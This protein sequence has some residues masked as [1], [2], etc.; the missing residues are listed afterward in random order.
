MEDADRGFHRAVQERGTG[1]GKAQLIPASSA[2]IDSGETADRLALHRDGVRRGHG[3]RQ[4]D[5]PGAA[6]CTRSTRW[7]SLRTFAM[8][9]AYA[10]ERGIIHRDIKPANIMVGQDGAVKVAD[11]GLAKVSAQ[12][13]HG[14]EPDP[15]RQCVMGT[16]HYMA[17]EALS[18]RERR[19]P[20]GGHLRRRRD[21]LPDAHREAPAGPV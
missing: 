3:C 19:G 2:S 8:L 9:S 14:C 13:S 20:E 15:Q 1:D 6:A 7:R 21:A 16:L 17:P 5:L 11:F 18:A 12:R 4:N 10:H